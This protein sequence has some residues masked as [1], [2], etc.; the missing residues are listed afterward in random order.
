M[1]TGMPNACDEDI[2]MVILTLNLATE[3]RAS[4]VVDKW[5]GSVWFG[6]D[7]DNKL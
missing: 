3:E 4:R 1:A 6:E 7:Y 2:N 5:Q